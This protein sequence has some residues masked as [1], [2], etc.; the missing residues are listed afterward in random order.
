ME[1]LPWQRHRCKLVLV[2]KAL[3]VRGPGFDSRDPHPFS[4][5]NF[6]EKVLELTYIVFI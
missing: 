6:N 2:G 5:V 1:C 4:G 3:G